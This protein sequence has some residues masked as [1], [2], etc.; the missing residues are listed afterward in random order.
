MWNLQGNFRGSVSYLFESFYDDVLTVNYHN[1]M[2]EK[3]VIIVHCMTSIKSFNELLYVH[4]SGFIDRTM[5]F[6]F[7]E[8]ENI[9]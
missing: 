2:P 1:L 7:C 3:S 4:I 8:C 6:V 5:K 9:D